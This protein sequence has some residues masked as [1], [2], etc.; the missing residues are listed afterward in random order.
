M[1]EAI[2]E[3]ELETEKNRNNASILKQF[4]NAGLPPFSG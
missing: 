4:E 1:V 3:V 2:R